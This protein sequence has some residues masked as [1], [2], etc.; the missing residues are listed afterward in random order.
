MFF[1]IFFR[2]FFI[3]IFV[4]SSLRIEYNY[5]FN[6]LAAPCLSRSLS[7]PLTLYLCLIPPIFVYNHLI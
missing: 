1:S 2:M 5:T 4:N 3:Q 7:L 6:S